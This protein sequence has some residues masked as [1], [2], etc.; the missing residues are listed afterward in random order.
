MVNAEERG[1]GVRRGAGIDK[2][3]YS[4][5]F[6]LRLRLEVIDRADDVLFQVMEGRIFAGFDVGGG[7]SISG[8]VMVSR[9][10]S[11]GDLVRVLGETVGDAP[12]AVG[13]KTHKRDPPG[14]ASAA[15][16]VLEGKVGIGG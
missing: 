5:S 3:R 12:D 11:V 6:D 13:A 14:R 1:E 16:K 10:G 2:N 7:G 9:L 8:D 15:V 4:M